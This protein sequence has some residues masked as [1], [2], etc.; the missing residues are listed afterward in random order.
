MG[1]LGCAMGFAFTVCV[2]EVF[3]GRVQTLAW[4]SFV[5]LSYWRLKVFGVTIHIHV[6]LDYGEALGEED[7]EE[8]WV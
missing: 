1:A 4:L 6:D 5:H 2:V 8:F 7:S 3:F